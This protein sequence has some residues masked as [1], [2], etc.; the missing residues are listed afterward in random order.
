MALRSSAL[1]ALSGSRKWAAG[2]V[3][4][5]VYGHN[6]YYCLDPIDLQRRFAE[7]VR[8]VMRGH[9]LRNTQL[10]RYGDEFCGT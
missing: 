10:W 6:R 1:S 2:G 3:K 5:R 8:Q 7:F 9:D 4:E